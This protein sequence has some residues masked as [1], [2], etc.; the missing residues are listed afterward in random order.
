VATDEPAPGAWVTPGQPDVPSAYAGAYPSAGWT[1]PPPPPP[2]GWV[3]NAAPQAPRPG[4][5]PLRPLAVGELLDG[6]FTTIRRYPR[7][8]LGLSAAVMVVVEAIQLVTTYWLLHNVQNSSTDLFQNSQTVNGS[9]GDFAARTATV[10]GILLV[11][12]L[13][14]TALLSGMLAAV[15]GEGVLGRPMSAAQAWKRTRESF[16]SLLGATALIFLIGVGILVAAVVP[17]I[18]VLAA[19]A[20]GI[21]VALIVI[22]GVIAVPYAI[23]IYLSLAF[24]TPALMLERQGIRAA[25]RRSRLLIRHSWWRVFGILLLTGLIAGVM[26][27]IVGAPFSILGGGY[28]VFSGHTHDQFRFVPLLLTGI[29]GLIGGTL[30]RP[31]SAGVTALLYLDRRMRAEALD[32]TLQQAAASPPR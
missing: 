8:T 3:P 32:L 23:Y 25:M 13:V 14:A 1:G 7:A 29:G 5:I 12:T 27:G 26:A 20:T 10:E 31:F 18:V 22:G 21:G 4:V 2:Y 30:A 15:I 11:V 6:G 9:S 24:T 28:S 17:G 19:G 16:W